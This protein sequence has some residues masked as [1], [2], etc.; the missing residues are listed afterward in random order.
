MD[1]CFCAPKL[2]YASITVSGG[3]KLVLSL[4][5]TYCFGRISRKLR[6]RIKVVDFIN[7]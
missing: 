7:T 5:Y 6:I 4:K 2:L 3:R 1:I